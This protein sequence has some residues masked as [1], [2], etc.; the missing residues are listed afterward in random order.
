MVRNKKERKEKESLRFSAIITIASKA[1]ARSKQ[2][3]NSAV[4]VQY[5]A[6]G[7]K[8]LRAVYRKT[9]AFV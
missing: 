8:V 3:V 5:A 1:A 7:T 2:M 6:L 9:G 4:T